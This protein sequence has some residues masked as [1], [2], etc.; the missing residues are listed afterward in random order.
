MYKFR[1]NI[2]R[3]NNVEITY[4]FLKFSLNFIVSIDLFVYIKKVNQ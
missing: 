2:I 4:T 3:I 1:I